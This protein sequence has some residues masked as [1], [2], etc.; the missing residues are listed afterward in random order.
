MTVQEYLLGKG[1]DW[2]RRGDNGI[3]YILTN[4]ITKK[5]YVGQTKQE[6]KKRIIGHISD[7]KRN[8]YPI[9]NS[10]KKYGTENFEIRFREYPVKFLDRIEKW[11]IFFVKSRKPY[12]Y[13]LDGGGNKNK[14]ISLETRKKMSVRQ[15]G[16]KNY[17]Y[18]KC[19]SDETKEKISKSHIGI[20]HTEET[21]EKLRIIKTGR[22][23]GPMPEYQKKKHSEALIGRPHGPMSE[24]TKKKIGDFFRG[25]KLSK[26]H[27]AKLS[28]KK[29]EYYRI[30]NGCN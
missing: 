23:I 28:D 5:K 7:C 12:G 30:K 18:G 14:N 21:K 24:E 22:K 20:R 16:E 11:L 2:K 4:K 1:F 15:I 8:N 26:R 10:I 3:I 9:L 13:N 19:R 29:K 17:W 6:L 27:K 25:K